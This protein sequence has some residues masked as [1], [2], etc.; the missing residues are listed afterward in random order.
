MP[1][2]RARLAEWTTPSCAS[3]AIAEANGQHART[4][5]IL[6]DLALGV[7]HFLAFAVEAGAITSAERDTLAKRC[8]AA[9]GE[10]AAAQAGHVEAAEPCGQFLRL[11]AGAV[12]SGRCTHHGP[13]GMEPSNPE[14]WGWRRGGAPGRPQGKRIGW[15]NAEGLFLQPDAAFVEA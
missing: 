9:L 11:L 10:A 2:F 1:D 3:K 8:W 15:L 13:D 14:A 7:K 5:G 4:P 12:A 6:A